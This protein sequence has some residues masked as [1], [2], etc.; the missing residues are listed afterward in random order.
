[1]VTAFAVVFA[2]A[3]L[4]FAG[5]V[6]DGGMILASKREAI[7][8]AEAAARVGAQALDVGT[9]RSSGVMTL[10]AGQTSAAAQQYLASAGATGT[11]VVS[12]DVVQ[13]TVTKDQPMEILGIGG[14]ASA[15]VSGV[16]N[17]HVQAAG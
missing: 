1:M 2:M 15:H 11:V 14:L 17:A 12:G 3:L 5:L 13:V 8:Q 7:D 9:Y 4:L 10:D 6:F 16:G